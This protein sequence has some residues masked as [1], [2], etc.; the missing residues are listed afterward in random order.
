MAEV[1]SYYEIELKVLG[2]GTVTAK[3]K[4]LT[5]AFEL[6]S[7]ATKAINQDI[8]ENGTAL[9]GTTRYYNQEIEKVTRLR[10]GVA[11]TSVEYRKYTEAIKELTKKKEALRA[12]LEGTLAAFN[13]ELQALRDEQRQLARNPADWARYEKRIGSV[14]KNIDKLTNSQVL[15]TRSNKDMISNS[16]L[17]GATITEFGRTISDANYGLRGMANNLSQLSTLFI[18]LISKTGSL[19]STWALLRKQM[20]GPLGLIV[21]FQ[22]IVTLM[23]S[24]AIESDKA[25]ESTSALSDEL[26]QQSHVLDGLITNL[27]NSNLE[28][29]ERQRL[30]RVLGKVDKEF[31]EALNNN[32]LSEKER[33]D[34]LSK[35]SYFLEQEIKFAKGK[36]EVEKE[37]KR[38]TEENIELDEKEQN[39]ISTYLTSLN[40]V[41]TELD[42][43]KAAQMASNNVMLERFK[44]REDLA[45][46]DEKEID[47]IDKFVKAE[48]AYKDAIKSTSEEQSDS[49]AINEQL[50]KEL[51]EQKLALI[52]AQEA[53]DETSAIKK[54]KQ[55]SKINAALLKIEEEAAIEK[56]KKEEYSQAQLEAIRIKYSMKRDV[57][58]LKTNS[59]LLN[60]KRE[61][62]DKVEDDLVKFYQTTYGLDEAAAKERIKLAKWAQ[63]EL[64]KINE[65]KSDEFAE[66]AASRGYDGKTDKPKTPEEIKR[67]QER[68]NKETIK[69]AKESIAQIEDLFNAAYDAEI[70]R[71]EAKTARLNNELRKRLKN[72][73]LTAK[74]REQLNLQIASNEEKLQEK[75]DKLAE[76]QFKLQK[77]ISIGQALINT[78]EMAS[79]AFNAVLAGP[80]KF[81]GISALALAK[82]AAGITTAFGLAQVNAI[83]KQQF[84]PSALGSTSVSSSGGT[85][86]PA[87]QAPDF[88]IVGQSGVNQLR[89]LIQAQSERPVKAYV[90]SKDISTA[91]ELDRNKVS[92][93]SL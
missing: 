14:K 74:Q 45:K 34:L 16:G 52:E 62:N 90:V 32:N 29:E 23:E 69:L 43:E 12:P 84:V 9:V 46:Q 41:P 60:T 66:F 47:L 88:N 4:D 59:A 56:A 38:L 77:A 31:Y 2:Q 65:G 50:N 17:A 1:K 86:A 22:G 73:N 40:R 91:Q 42:K 49:L 70:S 39:L 5:N 76:K 83:R 92:S 68:K 61:Y 6:L 71:E 72:E 26:E 11:N 79:R 48:N 93:A 78:Y 85:S 33:N 15:N 89:D 67:E 13:K 28:L 80:E 21:L 57:L 8:I 63:G 20:M 3:V 55:I 37:R 25:K 75:R 51:L 87:I 19:K 36:A 82:V 35:R 81:L 54:V 30:M 24:F 10:D 18:T 64:K 58:E 53:V 7:D 27:K 44:I